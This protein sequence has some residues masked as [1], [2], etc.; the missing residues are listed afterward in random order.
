MFS[1]ETS[2]TQNTFNTRMANQDA[3]YSGYRSSTAFVYIGDGTDDL[4]TVLLTVH[5]PIDTTKS[6]GNNYVTSD[7]AGVTLWELRTLINDIFAPMI[8]SAP[9][10]CYSCIA[11]DGDGST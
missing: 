5:G 1:S 3:P 4:N 9:G 8:P 10:Y 6:S 2:L 11:L 7:Y